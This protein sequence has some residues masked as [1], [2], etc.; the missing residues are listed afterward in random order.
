MKRLMLTLPLMLIVLLFHALWAQT[1]L[2]DARKAVENKKWEEGKKILGKIIEQDDKNARAHFLYGECFLNLQDYDNAIKQYKKAADLAPKTAFYHFRLGQALGMKADHAGMFTQARLAPQI[3]NAFEKA[4]KLDPNLKQAHIGLANFYMRAPGFM[5]G[6]L[7]K[8]EQHAK[9][10][11]KLG[12]P[13]GKILLAKVYIKKDK[14][15]AALKLYRELEKEIGD[16]PEYVSYYND[17]GNFLLKRK[18]YDKAIEIFKM[19]VNLA[20]NSAKSYD[21]LGD[22]YR[23]AGKIEEAKQQYQKALKIDPK[24][25][26]S[27]DKLDDL[28]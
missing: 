1:L 24:Y 7:D 5:G 16:N 12:S 27:I 25:E 4:A 9:T 21:N 11:I 15:D 2:D 6:D 23:E 17:Y 3:K 14:P 8:A 10:L 20:P 18:K 28:E 13:D 26:P 19:Q 22:A